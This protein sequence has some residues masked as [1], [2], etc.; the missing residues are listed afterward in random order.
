MSDN[1]FGCSREVLVKH[2]PLKEKK[3]MYN[4]VTL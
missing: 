4:E 2:S 1:V 3:V